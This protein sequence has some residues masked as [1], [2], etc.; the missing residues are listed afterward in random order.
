MAEDIEVTGP[1]KLTTRQA[2]CM[3]LVR[4]GLTSKQ[5]ARELGI[6]FRT[7]DQHI[8]T[9]IE[10]LQVNNR[11]AAVTRLQEIE[12]E[13]VA[14]RETFMFSGNA[15]AEDFSAAII[16]Q[17]P[18]AVPTRPSIQNRILPPLGGSANRNT[19]HVRKIWMV[20][21]ATISIM[22]SCL[23]IVAIL[24]LSELAG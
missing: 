5:I 20:R 7:V 11:M 17:P 24:G 4:K 14:E 18:A 8:A 10:I 1:P 22:L 6:S 19:P 15:L 13:K 9:V 2:D 21:I 12:E 16:A 3:D 23:A